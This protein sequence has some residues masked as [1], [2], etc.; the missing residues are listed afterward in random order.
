MI[1][2]FVYSVKSQ[3]CHAIALSSWTHSVPWCLLLSS[4][5]LLL[6]GERTINHV[7]DKS[8]SKGHRQPLRIWDGKEQPFEAQSWHHNS[9]RSFHNR[10]GNNNSYLTGPG[11]RFTNWD[12]VSNS[13]VRPAYGGCGILYNLCCYFSWN[14]YHLIFFSLFFVWL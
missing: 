6:R 13:L 7:Q 9:T 3:L 12:N 5:V 2:H 1:S 4:V 11:E 8:I 10:A 14:L